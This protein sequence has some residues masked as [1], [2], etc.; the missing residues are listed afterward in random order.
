M[1]DN[2]TPILFLTENLIVKNRKPCP[3]PNGI[4]LKPET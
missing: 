4:G 2:S 1:V 3:V